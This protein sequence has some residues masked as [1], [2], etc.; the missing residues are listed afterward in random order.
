VTF[1]RPF[2][3]A[4]AM[5]GAGILA[6]CDTNDGRQLEPPTEEQRAAMTTTTTTPPTLAPGLPPEAGAVSSQT[7]ATAAATFMLTAPWA[8]G[9][10]IPA[11]FTCDGQDVSPALSWTAPP[12]GT[13]ELALVVTDDDAGG[14]VHWALAGIAP[15]A[16]GIAEDGTLP[17]SIEGATSFGET[18]WGGPCPPSGTHTYRFTL[19]ALSQQAEV[20]DGFGES[21]LAVYTDTAS[22]AVAQ[23][24]G[25]YTRG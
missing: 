11:R 4:V 5:V 16:G 24:T 10:P 13:V 18:G 3:A 12:A 9:R 23:M 20:A 2:L 17:G 14:F 8:D 7:P 1:A 6:G 15:S 21:E 22:L 19:Y 25:T